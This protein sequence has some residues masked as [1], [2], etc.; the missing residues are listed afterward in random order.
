MCYNTTQ[1]KQKIILNKLKNTTDLSDIAILEQ[2]LEELQQQEITESFYNASGFD[3]PIM[4]VEV[5]N[6]TKFELM[7]WGLIP[8]WSQDKEKAK[9]LRVYTINARG[10]TMFEKPSFREA[11]KSK[12]CIL[13]V[14]S[15]FEHYHYKGKTYPHLI[16]YKND[17]IMNLAALFD[18]WVDKESGE[19][20]KT[21]TI[22]TTPANELM[23]KI[24]NNPK[25]KESR[26]P[27]I[28]TNEKQK[29]WLDGNATKD[30]ILELVKPLVSDELDAMTV[31]RL[32]GKEYIGNVEGLIENKLYPELPDI[33][34]TGE[35]GQVS[36]F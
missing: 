2:Q 13:P 29:I 9:S 34:G 7:E 3:N 22:V 11:A 1:L 32:R 23:S 19:M 17:E 5:P 8:Q 18:E 4:L 33:L 20:F 36:L 28:L 10:E 27:L 30:E 24:H 16:K 15:F 26:M 35:I 12:R 14:N 21:F 25:A 31:P 6:Q